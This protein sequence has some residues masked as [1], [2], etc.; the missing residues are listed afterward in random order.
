M[1]KFNPIPSLDSEACDMVRE[2]CI[3]CGAGIDRIAKKKNL[4]QHLLVKLFVYTF[5]MIADKVKED[6]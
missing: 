1:S 6:E 3:A 2:L 4:P 5:E